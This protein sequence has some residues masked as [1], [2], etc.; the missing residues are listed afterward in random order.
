MQQQVTEP[1]WSKHT[2]RSCTGRSTKTC[3]GN[4][5]EPLWSS[6]D[7]DNTDGFLCKSSTSNLKYSRHKTHF[8][9]HIHLSL[10]RG[11]SNTR[12]RAQRNRQHCQTKAVPS[13]C[14][15]IYLRQPESVLLGLTVK[16]IKFVF[17]SE[18][19]SCLKDSLYY[20]LLTLMN[21]TEGELQL[22][23]SGMVVNYNNTRIV[24][25]VFFK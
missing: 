18:S 9:W 3:W 14:R 8:S 16:Y 1:E 12:R 24:S 2:Q 11:L 22:V 4:C 7:K 17:R 13:P 6:Q 21:P 20:S 5:E 19:H 10:K 15:F 25:S 23:K